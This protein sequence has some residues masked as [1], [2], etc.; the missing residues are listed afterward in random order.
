VD[1]IKVLRGLLPI[2]SHCKKIRDEQGRWHTVEAYVKDRAD[3][4]FSHGICPDC[5]NKHY[6]QF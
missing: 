4:D 2:C 6:S 3:V 1:N 5:L